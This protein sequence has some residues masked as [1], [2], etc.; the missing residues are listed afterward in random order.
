MRAGGCSICIG[1]AGY[2]GCQPTRASATSS[3]VRRGC[4]P[5]WPFLKASPGSLPSPAA[6]SV[7]KL[8]VQVAAAAKE[9]CRLPWG[10]FSSRSCPS[11]FQI[12]GQRWNSHSLE[13]WIAVRKRI[14]LESYPTLLHEISCKLKQKK[15]KTVA[16]IN[17]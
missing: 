1:T 12:R 16:V 5:N 9:D 8:C 17:F 3:S 14:N 13:N 6:K 4:G 15:W 7:Q 2:H 11:S 10:S